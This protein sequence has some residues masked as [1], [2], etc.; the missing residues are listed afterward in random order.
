MDAFLYPLIQIPRCFPKIAESVQVNYLCTW[1]LCARVR[2]TLACLVFLLFG[3]A[4][5]KVNLFS[6]VVIIL[7]HYHIISYGLCGLCKVLANSNT[8]PRGGGHCLIG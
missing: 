4:V 3:F 2:R 7:N 8:K 5:R 1:Q 6:V